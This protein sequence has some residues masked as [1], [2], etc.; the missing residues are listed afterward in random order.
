LKA[1]KEL[2]N[3]SKCSQA[4]HKVMTIAVKALLNEFYKR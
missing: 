4:K 3:A 2:D 1:T